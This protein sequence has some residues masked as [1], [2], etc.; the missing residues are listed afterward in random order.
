[1]AHQLTLEIPDEVFQRLLARAQATGQ[2]VAA[3]ATAC[4]SDAIAPSAPG[5]RLLPL[6]GFWASHVPDGGLRHDEYLGQALYEE[7]NEPRHD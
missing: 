3:V 5:A 7:L 4:L 1:M 6:E 2:T